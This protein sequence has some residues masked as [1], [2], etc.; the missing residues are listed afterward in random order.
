MVSNTGFILEQIPKGM[1]IKDFR[2]YQY[3]TQQS[4]KPEEVPD[5]NSIDA[6]DYLGELIRRDPAILNTQ[7]REELVRKLERLAKRNAD[8]VSDIDIAP[9]PYEDLQL[10]CGNRDNIYQ[11]LDIIK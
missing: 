8:R 1:Q 2:K 10:Y 9:I 7:L 6:R 4:L 11:L 5:V 3:R